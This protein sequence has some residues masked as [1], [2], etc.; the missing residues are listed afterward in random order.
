MLLRD[1]WQG[2]G[3]AKWGS[4]FSDGVGDRCRVGIRSRTIFWVSVEILFFTAMSTAENTRKAYDQRAQE[5]EQRGER[6]EWRG[7]LPEDREGARRKY[8][9]RIYVKSQGKAG[10]AEVIK[11]C[12]LGGKKH[13]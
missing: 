4:E 11:T 10:N 7:I 12:K 3:K 8:L 9:I 2:L 5:S 6:G 13:M 1:P